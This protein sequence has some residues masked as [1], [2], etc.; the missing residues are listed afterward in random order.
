M[1][2]E[3]AARRRRLARMELIA[4]RGERRR[5]EARALRNR[6]GEREARG[7]RR[8]EQRRRHGEGKRSGG[9]GSRR[10]RKRRR[11]VAESDS[12]SGAESVSATVGISL[13]DGGTAVLLA[14]GTA[15]P[16]YGEVLLTT[17]HHDVTHLAVAL[18]VVTPTEVPAATKMHR[19]DGT[20]GARPVARR[21]LIDGDVRGWQ[22][23]PRPV[24]PPAVRALEERLRVL[25][26]AADRPR[27]PAARRARP[28]GHFPLRRCY[29]S[30]C[31]AAG[32]SWHARGSLPPFSA[33]TT[34]TS[35]RHMGPRLGRSQ[36]PA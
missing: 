7:R 1:Q 6:A 19:A 3:E 20:K 21:G 18:R 4:E 28:A 32:R 25:R 33:H 31:R 29:G 22:R 34:C 16:A 27:A 15:L 35:T 24:N 17:A 36:R 30:T 11:V 9:G 2:L 13:A 12:D 14:A 5:Q 8:R 23:A 10:V 26:A